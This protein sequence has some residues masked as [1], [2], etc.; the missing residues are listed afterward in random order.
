MIDCITGESDLKALN[1]GN[2]Y[3]AWHA[4]RRTQAGELTGRM[5]IM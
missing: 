4:A 5:Q 2:I 3:E 1:L